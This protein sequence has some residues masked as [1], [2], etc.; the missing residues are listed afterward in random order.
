M[1]NNSIQFDELIKKLEDYGNSNIELY[2]YKLIDKSSVILSSFITLRIVA[3]GFTLFFLVFSMGLALW[4][5]EILGKTYYGIFIMSGIYGIIAIVLYVSREK[6]RQSI[7][8]SI[9]SKAF[10]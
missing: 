8:D 4:L 5:G 7:C 2:K 1:E 6:I 10:N 3:V 9:I